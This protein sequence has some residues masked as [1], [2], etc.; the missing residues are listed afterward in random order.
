MASFYI[1]VNLLQQGLPVAEVPIFKCQFT[2]I[3][4]IERTICIWQFGTVRLAKSAPLMEDKMFGKH[5]RGTLQIVM[6][7]DVIDDKLK[8]TFFF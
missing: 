8:L 5:P 2:L 3:F 1:W 4:K 7:F 6:Y